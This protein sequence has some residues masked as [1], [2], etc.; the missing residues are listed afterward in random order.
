MAGHSKW[1]NIKNRKGAVDQQRAAT[2]NVLAKQIR[3]AVKQSGSGDPK[4]NPTVR[5]LL[6]KAREANMPK[7]KIQRAIDS[8]L[9]KG[10]NGIINEVTYEGYGPGGVAILAVA[11]TDNPNRTA[12]EIRYIFSRNGGNLSGPNSAKFMFQWVD[13][14]YQSTMPVEITDPLVA[15]QLQELY[16]ELSANE[17]VEDVYVSADLS[18]T[19]SSQLE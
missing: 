7:E 3:I 19:D 11:H 4:A 14:S 18:E 6:D 9:G 10:S 8:G 1:N 17:D 2:F 13:D 12:S 16:A 15:Q 5:M